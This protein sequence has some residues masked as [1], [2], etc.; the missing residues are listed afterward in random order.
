MFRQITAAAAN[1]QAKPELHTFTCLTTGLRISYTGP[2]SV[3]V[4][5]AAAESRYTPQYLYALDVRRKAKNADFMSISREV[6]AERF[7]TAGAVYD[8]LPGKTKAFWEMKSRSHL[9]RQPGI[10]G[11][12]IT[13]LR[14][15]PT[16]SYESVS[17]AIDEWCSTATIQ[18]FFE[19]LAVCETIQRVIPFVNSE[20]RANSV[21]F[22]KRVRSNWGLGPGKYLWIHFDEK[23]MLGM[24]LRKTKVC[25]ALGLDPVK[26][27]AKHRNH[28]TK[29]MVLALVGFAF[30][31]TPENGGTGVL[32]GIHRVQAAKIAQK[33]QRKTTK[34]PNGET[35][36]RGDIIRR[37]GD[38][39]MVDCE[40]TGASVGT[41][42][43]RKMSL[44]KLFEEA[45]LIQ[46]SDLVRPGAQF[47]GYR[48]IFQLDNGGPHVKGGFVDAMKAFCA[49]Q[50]PAWAWEPQEAQMPYSNWLDLLVFP[51]LSRRHAHLLAEKRQGRTPATHD[52]IN[53]TAHNAFWNIE[54]ANV[55]TAAVLMYRLMEEVIST[56]GGTHFLTETRGTHRGV[57]NDFTWT[58]DGTGLCRKDGKKL[59]APASII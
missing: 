27:Y 1:E 53:D 45:V 21:T 39:F 49:R 24:L 51:L 29:L 13:F 33:M 14:V 18:R 46:I 44:L 3:I 6:S 37:A 52:E 40:L 5:Y 38:V 55:A 35:Q 58:K 17:K 30:E 15:D 12:I 50:N 23:W 26:Y 34:G 4:D 32:L 20:Q 59:A 22:A 25:E 8:S 9:A 10:L 16:R 56:G 42:K 54:G 41:S 48:V 7:T 47:A 57:R 11:E 19:S 31:D 2:K 28:I 43:C 36:Y